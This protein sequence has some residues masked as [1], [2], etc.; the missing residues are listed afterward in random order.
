ML[1][2]LRLSYF[3][4]NPNPANVFV[5]SGG[6]NPTYH[7]MASGDHIFF[8][9]ATTGDSFHIQAQ[10]AP[11]VLTIEAAT[12]HRAS[13]CHVQAQGVLAN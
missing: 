10:G 6:D 11:G 13:D 12:V 9:A 3:C 2:F 1:G 5:E 4:P 8:G 7:Q